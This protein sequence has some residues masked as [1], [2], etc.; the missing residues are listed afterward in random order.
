MHNLRNRTISRIIRETGIGEFFNRVGSAI[1]TA[2][3]LETGRQ[4][5]AD[6]LRRLGIDS[7]QFNNVR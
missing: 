7:M 6:D 1:S 2:A 5:N 3:A 4:P